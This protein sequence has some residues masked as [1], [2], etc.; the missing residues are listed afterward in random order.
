MIGDGF[1]TLQFKRGRQELKAWVVVVLLVKWKVFSTLIN[2]PTELWPFD[3]IVHVFPFGNKGTAA[4]R[5]SPIVH[6]KM[7]Q[8]EKKTQTHAPWFGTR[9][10]KN[11]LWS[12]SL[13]YLVLFEISREKFLIFYLLS[14]LNNVVWIC[15]QF[16]MGKKFFKWKMIA[17]GQEFDQQP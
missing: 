2:D 7:I 4:A 17:S 1:S 6:Q 5:H 11:E 12:S 9:N 15:M 10:R 14:L 13:H 16:K 3:C 8:S